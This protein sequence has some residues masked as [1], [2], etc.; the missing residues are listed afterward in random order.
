MVD[1][2]GNLLD[3]VSSHPIHFHL[4]G[5]I[6]RFSAQFLSIRGCKLKTRVYASC[7]SL[8][9]I[10]NLMY[11]GKVKPARVYESLYMTVIMV[12]HVQLCAQVF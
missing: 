8:G 4:N 10:H 11:M 9:C 12:A 7:S 1:G 2:I 5:L 3:Q 6:F